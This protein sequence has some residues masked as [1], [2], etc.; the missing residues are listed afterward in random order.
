MS[1]GGS[2]SSSGGSSSTNNDYY[3][4]KPTNDGGGEKEAPKGGSFGSRKS[5]SDTVDI[6]GIPKNGGGSVYGASGYESKEPVVGDKSGSEPVVGDDKDKKTDGKD[7]EKKA[8]GDK[9]TDGKDG[10]KKPDG[11]KKADEKKDGDKKTDGKDG[12]KKADEGKKPEDGDKKPSG[13]DKFSDKMKDLVKKLETGLAAIEKGGNKVFGMAAMLGSKALDMLNIGQRGGTC[14]LSSLV[15]Q[16]VLRQALAKMQEGGKEA[17]M[18][19]LQGAKGLYQQ[20]E[21]ALL[22]NGK[23]VDPGGGTTHSDQIANMKKAGIYDGSTSNANFNQIFDNVA[24]GRTGQI[25][26]SSSNMYSA[27]GKGGGG[28]GGID[29]AVPILGA[30]EKQNGERVLICGD[31]SGILTGKANGTYEITESAFRKATMGRGRADYTWTKP[32]T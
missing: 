15:K 27:L 25:N 6:S 5:E 8:D 32:I 4:P 16:Q 18:S 20:M 31:T 30:R 22:R 23:H 13:M 9:K 14:G 29:H 3:R 26:I 12:E 7:G 1:E 10:D 28:G 24:G 21:N 11:E 19:F 2:V 17:A